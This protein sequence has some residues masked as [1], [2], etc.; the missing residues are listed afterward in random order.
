[1]FIRKLL[2][3][4]SKEQKKIILYDV[5]TIQKHCNN[6]VMIE[7]KEQEENAF[8]HN[9]FCPKC[10]A[11]KDNIINRYSFVQGKNTFNGFSFKTKT[12]VL[13]ETYPVNHCNVCGNE[14][15]K[16]KSKTITETSIVK[17]ILNYLSD[18]INEPEKNV[19]RKWKHESISIFDDCHAESICFLQKKYK[20][21]LHK[22]ISISKLRLKYKSIYK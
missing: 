6:I 17:V 13:F 16:F 7:T 8:V 12:I 20:G 5:E 4:P 1:M 9:N 15:I 19:N 21:W 11:K 18:I 2:H 3:L 14:W 22:P 10:H